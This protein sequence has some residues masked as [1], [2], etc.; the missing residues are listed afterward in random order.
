ME[1]V[2]R[3][4]SVP[5][6]RGHVQGVAVLQRTAHRVEKHWTVKGATLSENA[7]ALGRE[8]SARPYGG[9]RTGVAA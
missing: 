7:G 8:S 1:E 6:P 9:R 2:A 4:V 5:S 3:D